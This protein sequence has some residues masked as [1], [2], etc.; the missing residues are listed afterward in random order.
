MVY[1]QHAGLEPT[2]Y[3]LDPE[4]PHLAFGKGRRIV[5]PV[6]H[7]PPFIRNL[8]RAAVGVGHVSFRRAL[9]HRG[10]SRRSDLVGQG[11][12]SLVAFHTAI[13]PDGQKSTVITASTSPITRSKT[14]NKMSMRSIFTMLSIA[15]R[16]SPAALGPY[17]SSR[18]WTSAGG[19]VASTAVKVSWIS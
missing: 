14:P 1:V 2:I 17:G 6:P 4:R 8:E 9:G 7:P 11:F 10:L 5:E 12:F 19:L 3:E 16:G 18:S 13:G 15:V